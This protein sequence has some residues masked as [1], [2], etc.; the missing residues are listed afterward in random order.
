M[1]LDKIVVE[2]PVESMMENIMRLKQNLIKIG[3][4]ATNKA[5]TLILACPLT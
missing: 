5:F 3:K 2:Q 4:E 1:Q